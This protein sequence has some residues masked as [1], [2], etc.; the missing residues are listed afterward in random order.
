MRGVSAVRPKGV[1]LG[2]D[3]MVIS[4]PIGSTEIA[5]EYLNDR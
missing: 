4:L 5:Y 2:V 1:S 3:G